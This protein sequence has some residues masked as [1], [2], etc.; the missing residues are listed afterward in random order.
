[1]NKI[2]K[3][4]GY[5]TLKGNQISQLMLVYMLEYYC[6]TL[7]SNIPANVGLCFN[8]TT[9]KSTV[10]AYNEALEEYSKNLRS[11]LNEEQSKLLL[12]PSL[13][14]LLILLAH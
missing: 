14:V 2:I 5:K 9:E 12:P 8:Y 3:E 7:N 6:E 1:M 4:A 13:L 10:I 11:T